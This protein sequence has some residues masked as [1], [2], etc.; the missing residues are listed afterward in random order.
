MAPLFKQ[1][2]LRD[3]GPSTPVTTTTDTAT[4][5]DDDVDMDAPQISTLRED[6]TPPPARG[7][8]PRVK[9][10]VSDKKGK[11]KSSPPSVSAATRKSVSQNQTQPQPQTEEEVDEED[12]EDQLID[13][14]EPAPSISAPVASVSTG[15]KR[16]APPKKPS[17]PRKGD[18]QDKEDKKPDGEPCPRFLYVVVRGTLKLPLLIEPREPPD[19]DG[20]SVSAAALPEKPPPKKKAPPRKTA[21][22]SKPK[23]KVPPK[24]VTVQLSRKPFLQIP[25]AEEPKLWQSLP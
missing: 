17:R 5:M 3:N 25:R 1:K 18:K 22:A 7:S 10:L 8:K 4:P 19:T 21:A 15:T 20:Q 12:E 9:L 16:K 13:D 24:Y 2:P 6:D 11:G 23:I 14:D